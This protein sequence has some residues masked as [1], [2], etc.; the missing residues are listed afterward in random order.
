MAGWFRRRT[1]GTREITCIQRRIVHLPNEW[2]PRLK[3]STIKVYAVY[4]YV[5]EGTN[6][7][8]NVYRRKFISIFKIVSEIDTAL[9]GLDQLKTFLQR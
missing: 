2:S 5:I 7:R 4:L 9:V 8:G 6:V 1:I 3:V